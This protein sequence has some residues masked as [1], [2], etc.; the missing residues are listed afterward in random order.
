MIKPRL[1]LCS[2]AK[3]AP[4]DPIAV[5]RRSINLN[6]IGQ[7]ANV[8]IRFENVAKVFGRQLTP[9]L[10]DFLEIAAYVFSADCATR[11]GT[12]WTA[13]DSTEAW[14]RDFAFVIAVRD[15]AFWNSEAI[16]TQIADVLTFL[17]D[18]RYSFTFIPLKRER[19]L[20]QQYLDFGGFEDWPFHA[21]DRVLMF[22]GGLDSLAGAVETAKRGHNSV[23]VS[24]RPVSTM[25][26][27]QAK[28]FRELERLFPQRFLHLPVWINKDKPLGQ[29]P[30]QRTR[31]FLFAALGTLVGE[32]INARGVRFFENGVVS[33]NLPVADEVLRSRASRTTH[34]IAL[35]LLRLL[36]TAVVK[37]D[38]SV[39]NPYFFKT[40]TEVIEILASCGV[41]ELIGHTCSCARSMFKP[42]TRWHCGKCS[43]C[44][45]RR[46]A[47]LAAG[48]QDYERSNDYE[49]DVFVGAR[50][51]GPEKNIAAD[52]VRHGTE[53]CQRSEQDLMSQFSA[54]LS[55][56]VRHEPKRTEAAAKIVRMHQRHGKTVA[57]VLEKVITERAGDLAKGTLAATSLLGM[58]V[59]KDFLG[60]DASSRITDAD[61]QKIAR[62]VISQMGAPIRKK[63]SLLK[64]LEGRNTVIY[65]AIMLE[66]KGSGYCDYL[67]N[68]GLKP[69]WRDCGP[70]TYRKSYD[71][72]APWR[73]KI[74]DEKSRASARLRMY[75]EPQIREALIT[76]LPDEFDSI[77][78]QLDSRHSRNSR[79]ASST[80][81]VS[82]QA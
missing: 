21:P 41:P 43:Q 2:G 53:L 19:R 72:G 54:E 13:G 38:F 10:V 74:Q 40:K 23:L 24:H 28:L 35:H 47:V 33:L 16:R 65:A 36:C 78:E 67:D 76:H 48:L 51:D 77:S 61:A 45:D 73:K 18:D 4:D 25:S 44:I 50:S 63:T 29:E 39:D 62:A 49:S 8:N 64:K 66:R 57:C 22:S 9:R 79:N 7:D 59:R 60:K 20:Q 17:S 46:F 71:V 12:Q 14:N 52:Y 82:A 15:F 55:R 5:G 58:F 37:R 81:Q 42:M 11:R 30:T 3:V 56:A 27:R 32:S 1:F 75:S 31:S 70:T 69:K 68:H 34:P 80:P 6:S 26:A